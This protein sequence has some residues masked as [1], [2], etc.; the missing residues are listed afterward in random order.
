MFKARCAKAAKKRLRFLHLGERKA[1]TFVK[2]G[3]EISV[4]FA[5]FVRT[6]AR[7]G[8]DPVTDR[9]LPHDFVDRA[10]RTDGSVID[11]R[12]NAFPGCICCDLG[13][14]L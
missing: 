11:Q 9:R 10:H 1:C 7:P 3:G 13:Q 12:Q 14:G 6:N 8:N 4:R 5:I 2:T